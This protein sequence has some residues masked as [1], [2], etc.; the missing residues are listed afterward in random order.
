[1]RFGICFGLVLLSFWSS[2]WAG[3]WDSNTPEITILVY[4]QE[5]LSPQTLAAG[6]QQAAMILQA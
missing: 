1:M 5:D 6:E 2:A 4:H 3:D